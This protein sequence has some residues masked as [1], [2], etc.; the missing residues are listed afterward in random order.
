[1][2]R[3]IKL[4]Q[5]SLTP[6]RTSSLGRQPVQLCKSPH[7]EGRRA[8]F[9]TRSAVAIFKVL[10]TAQGTRVL[11]LRWALRIVDGLLCHPRPCLPQQIS[12]LSISAPASPPH[13]APPAAP[14]RTLTIITQPGRHQWTSILCMS[15]TA[16]GGLCGFSPFIL[17]SAALQPT[18]L[19]DL[20]GLWGPGDLSI[21]EDTHPPRSSCES[22]VFDLNM[23]CPS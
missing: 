2:A 7:S 13:K 22:I 18:F 17:L 3:L 5:N 6:S 8:S 10:I 4:G 21:Q 14:V 1:M 23:K 16:L 19:L 11:S 9:N 20:R 12:D 15:R